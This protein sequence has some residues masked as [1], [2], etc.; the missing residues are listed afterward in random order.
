MMNENAKTSL[1]L[2]EKAFDARPAESD[3]DG[4]IR[5]REMWESAMGALR[6]NIQMMVEANARVIESWGGIVRVACSA[7][8]CAGKGAAAQTASAHATA[9]QG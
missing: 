3:P 1:A 7:N 2:L 8:G 4:R 5:S 9:A 6:K